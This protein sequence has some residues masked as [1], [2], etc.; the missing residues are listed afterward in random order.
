MYGK[1]ASS[2]H[3]A[4]SQNKI[5]IAISI[6]C[7]A[8]LV[9]IAGLFTPS[10]AVF[11]ALLPDGCSTG[12]KTVTGTNYYGVDG[13]DGISAYNVWLNEGHTGD[14]AAFLKDLVGVKGEAGYAGTNGKSAYQLW[15]DAGNKGSSAEFITSLIGADGV[16]GVAGLSAYELWLSTGQNGTLQNFLNTLIGASGTSGANGINGSN[17]LSAYELWKQ[18]NSANTNKTVTEFLT[19]LVG[20]QGVKGDTGT[21]GAKGDTG[22][23][24]N[25]GATGEVGPSGPAGPSGAPGTNGTNGICTIGV[26]GHFG[27]FWDDQTQTSVEPANGMLLGHTDSS[28][29][30]TVVKDDGSALAPGERG[31]WLK[32]DQGGTYNIAFSAQLAKT[33]GTADLVS[34]WLQRY[35]STLH[36]IDYTNTNLGMANNSTELVAAWNFFVDVADGDRVRIVW[37]AS[38]ATS[39]IAAHAPVTNGIDIPGTPSIIVTV[40]QV[41]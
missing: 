7:A 30:V 38:N 2:L 4:E 16:D 14:E 3:K 12:I 20:A 23:I 8:L 6:G 22:A 9:A 29:G 21:T 13:V 41:R 15:L 31:S 19:S 28:N 17:G 39:V 33:G 11:S 5:N 37:H 26:G 36:N 10:S 40:N 1:S 35:N 24:G 18:S 34:I 32:F 25:S 27:S